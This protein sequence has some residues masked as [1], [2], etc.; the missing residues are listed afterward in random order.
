MVL[1]A[2]LADGL[3]MKQVRGRPVQALAIELEHRNRRKGRLVH[4]YSPGLS[5]TGDGG[6]SGRTIRQPPGLFDKRIRP[7]EMQAIATSMDIDRAGVQSISPVPGT[8]QNASHYQLI[9]AE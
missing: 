5:V 2:A 7:G 9:P 6:A 4:H 8:I 1:A 3:A